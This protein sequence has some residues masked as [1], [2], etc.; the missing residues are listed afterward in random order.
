MQ[1]LGT[2][3]RQY[4]EKH[5]YSQS[6]LAHLLNIPSQSKISSWESDHSIPDVFEAQ[7]LAQ[8]FDISLDVFLESACS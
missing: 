8:I 7:R 2:I 5:R 6:A 1:T 3:I 4:R